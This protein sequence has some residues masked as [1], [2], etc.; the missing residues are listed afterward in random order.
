METLV[1][2]KNADVANMTYLANARTIGWLKQLKNRDGGYLWKAITDTRRN[3]IPGE[4]NGYPVARSNRVRSDLDKGTSK[5]V[6][7]DLFFANWADLIVGEWG[8]IEI[9]P[10]PYSSYRV[11]SNGTA[12]ELRSSAN[13]YVPSNNSVHTGRTFLRRK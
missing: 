10:N 8:V 7:S 5:G 12:V 2:E 6:C 9:L 13:P 3:S 11:C 1:A 4:L